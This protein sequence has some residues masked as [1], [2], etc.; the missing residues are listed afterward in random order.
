MNILTVEKNILDLTTL[1]DDIPETQ[2]T[3]VDLGSDAKSYDGSDIIFPRL[4]YVED[5]SGPAIECDVMGQSVILP[6]AW[7]IFIGEEDISEVELIPMTALNARDFSVIITNPIDGFRHYFGT[8]KVKSVYTDY[9]WVLPKIKNGQAL[10]IPITSN[11]ENP[12]CLYITHSTSKIPN[13]L[14]ANDFM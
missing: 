8:I 4:V 14:S 5:Y 7:N 2:F 10:A 3:V 11:T 13:V 9:D 1:E 6:L 12:V